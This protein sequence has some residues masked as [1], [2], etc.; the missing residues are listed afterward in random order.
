[1]YQLFKQLI[2]PP[3]GP[4]L[5]ALAGLAAMGCGRRWGRWPLGLGLL[6]AWLL[7]TD[8]VVS[9]LVDAYVDSPPSQEIL[10]RAEAW[11]G[12]TDALVLVLGGGIRRGASA[13]GGYD[14]QPLTLER[15]RRGL[16]W[17]SRLHLPLAFS[18]GLPALGEPDR[19][20]ESSVVARVL[21]EMGAPPARWFEDRASNTREN[22]R[23]TA[24]LLRRHGVGKLILVTHGLHMPRAVAHFRA[25]MPELE[26]LPAPLHRDPAPGWH[27]GQWL[28]NGDAAAQGSYL[29]YEWVARLAGR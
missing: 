7:A 17:S 20:T 5:L 18:G 8:A 27:I 3:A 29:I 25:E 26:I 14:L 12:R 9:P 1:M 2:L 28:P 23:F 24:E 15:L 6:L 22:A 4:L 21:A 19:P 13:D 11:E 10:R 16:W